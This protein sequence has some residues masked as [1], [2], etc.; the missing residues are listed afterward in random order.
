MLQQAEQ[1]FETSLMV[2][3]ESDGLVSVAQYY[4]VYYTLI[5]DLL[6]AEID[7]KQHLLR[8]KEQIY[9]A[10]FKTRQGKE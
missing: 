3:Y 2:D 1:M 7:D 10:I 9:P 4:P 6:W 5:P 8:V